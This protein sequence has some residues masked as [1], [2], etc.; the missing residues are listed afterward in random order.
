[1]QA[2]AERLLE[3]IKILPLPAS[4][5]HPQVL[6]LNLAQLPLLPTL[7]GWLLGYPVIYL[8]EEATVDATAR[9]LSADLLL[10]CSMQAHAPMLQVVTSTD[11]MLM[12]ALNHR[13]AETDRNFF[14]AMK[15]FQTPEFLAFHDYLGASGAVHR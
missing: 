9:L 12:N 2:V 15:T 6:D 10:L 14:A 11:I 4:G 3:L 7:Q 8:V 5:L 13:L 1:M